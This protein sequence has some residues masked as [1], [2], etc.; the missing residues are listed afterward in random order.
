MMEIYEQIKEE[1]LPP[2]MQMV[3]DVCGIEAA[4]KMLKE[5][6]GMSVY[7]PKMSKIAP[8]IK[9]Y[10]RENPDKSRKAL[11]RTLKVSELYLKKFE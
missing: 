11:A 5:M 3:A 9:R 6:S 1:E 4:R 2:D 7:I 8:F 10:L